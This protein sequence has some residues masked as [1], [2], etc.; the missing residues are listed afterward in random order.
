[1]IKVAQVRLPLTHTEADLK[2]ELMKQL[3]LRAEEIE[4]CEIRKRSLDARRGHELCYSYV[5]AVALRDP[6]QEERICRRIHN[7]AIASVLTE[8]NYQIPDCGQEPLSGRPVIAGSGPAGLFAAWLLAQKGFRPIVIERGASVEKRTELVRHFWETGELSEQTNVQFGEGGA[9]TFSDGKL[10]TMVKDTYGRIRYVLKGFVDFGADPGILYLHKPHIGTDVLQR[11]VKNMREEICRLGGEFRFETTLTGLLAKENR[12]YAVSLEGT[13]GTQEL[14]TALL[15]LAIGHSARDT[16]KR[17]QDTLKMEPKAF[18]VGLRIEHLQETI[19][20]AQY[21]HGDS[22]LLGTH[23]LP[24]ADYKLSHTCRNGRG[25]YSFCM[26]PGGYVVNAS[27]EQ[28]HL[29]I[30]GMSN[31]ARDGRNANS[32]L[33]VT[34]TPEDFMTGN[35][36]T[37]EL[38]TALAGIDFQRKLEAAAYQLG[39]GRIP[40]QLY[41]DF[42]ENRVSRGF[43]RIQPDS[44]GSVQ[45]AN[46][47]NLLPSWMAESLFEGMEAF[48]RKLP[49]FADEE[50]VFSGIESRTSSPVRLL[51]QEKSLESLSMQGV[52]PCGEGAGYAGGITSA[53]IDG[54]KVAEAIIRRYHPTGSCGT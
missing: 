43:G 40:V 44:R 29:A 45:L 8:P 26:C 36:P 31:H 53:A 27:S 32:A 22:E 21:G 30:N 7:S 20:R 48:G 6:A 17:L 37:P 12:L 14:E 24:A 18:A 13:G 52:Y 4:R 49:G 46:L 16:L 54:I 3:R 2:K 28:G 34:V 35:L 5:I 51:R 47:R 23:M 41:G 39:A 50:A 11:V 1:M 19:D 10:N 9:G 38:P 33:V 42:K 15:I 25:I